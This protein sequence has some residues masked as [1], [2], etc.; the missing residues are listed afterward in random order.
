MQ[1][2][3]DNLTTPGSRSGVI[4]VLDPS[5]V[6]KIAA[7]EV[8][9][10]PA[11]VL[12]ELI[13]N[14]IDAGATRVDVAVEEA[15]FSMMRVS[16]NGCGMSRADLG[17][18]VLAHAT[19]KIRS[20]DDLFSIATMGFRGEALASI[21][22]VSRACVVTSDDDSGG[23]GWELAVE[24][25]VSGDIEPAPRTR[26]TTVTV[27]DLFFN[28][29][30]RKKFMKTA[31]GE[32]SAITKILEQ[33]AIPFP[34]IHFTATVDG[35]RVMDLPR[36]GSLR[37]RICSVAG[38]DFARGLVECEGEGEGEGGGGMS[39]LVYVSSPE[40]LQSKPRFQSLYVNLR[41]IDNDSVNF[42]VREAFA[43]YLG[44][45]NRPAFFCFLD[46]DPNKVDVNVH[47]TKQQMKFDDE[48]G[49]FG[50]IYHVVKEGLRNSG[51]GRKDLPAQGQGY[52]PASNPI[53]E[54]YDRIGTGG[55]DGAA[56]TGVSTVD[57]INAIFGHDT[58]GPQMSLDFSAVGGGR[59]SAPSVDAGAND[60][61]NAAVIIGD[62]GAA[63]SGRSWEMI[64]CYQIHGIFV[65]APIKNGIL[66]IDQHAAHERVLYEQALLDLESGRPV[67]QQLLL[68]I[69]IEMSP[70]E[71]AVV[72]EVRDSF[73]NL[74]FEI[75]DWS[76]NSVSVSAMPAFLR[77]G[78][79]EAAVRE[80]VRYLLDG[81]SPGAM[82][83][84]VKRFAAAFACGAAI[85]SGQKLSQEE[86]NALI[87][88]LFAADNPYACP[89]G[90]PTLVRISVDELTRRFLR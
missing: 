81:R 69:I 57:D 70:A 58:G 77:Y 4:Q 23:L 60:D 66:L 79:A 39:A 22:A 89:H 6:E 53:Q 86:M 65:L 46:V 17:R 27:R 34:G 74:G 71:K 32:Q 90:R 73:T 31:R 8:V 51:L 49:V 15:G 42:A 19:S 18:S 29:P 76:G 59:A 61:G 78:E 80:M 82:R 24:G 68:P 44:H 13:E 37:E 14:S 88:A 85:K 67:S 5:V 84:P 43:Q 64:Q 2:N 36:V 45:G 63:D 10:R 87:N 16:D 41:R 35:K 7:G 25:G 52:C 28:V 3:N 33:L 75:A 1:E 21:S 12:K 83:E 72:D 38:N 55:I 26:G 54:F 9:E 50:F 62:I 30:A 56:G 20:A 48:R 11:S 47:P 40:K